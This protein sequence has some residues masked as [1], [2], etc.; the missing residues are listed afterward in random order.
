MQEHHRK[1]RYYDSGREKSQ[2]ISA[3]QFLGVHRRALRKKLS[4][5]DTRDEA[6]EVRGV[7]HVKNQPHQH[8]VH[9]HTKHLRTRFARLRSAEAERCA[10]HDADQAAES[11]GRTR[12]KAVALTPIKIPHH[13]RDVAEYSGQEIQEQKTS[14]TV[15]ALDA[16]AEIE[17]NHGVHRE[18]QQ[19]D[20]QEDG[21]DEP[22]PLAVEDH[23][24]LARTELKE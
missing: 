17:K 23:Q 3:L 20:M 18:V 12:S 19:T 9:N 24:R 6:A 21:H 22:P 1:A 15:S 13:A 2:K 5:D 16:R 7:V 10:K 11:T 4:K 8:E 14:R